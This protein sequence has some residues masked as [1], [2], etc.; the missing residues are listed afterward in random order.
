[1]KLA[2]RGEVGPLG[3]KANCFLH[4]SSKECVH[5]YIEVNYQHW[6]QSSPLEMND[7]HWHQ[8]SPLEVNYHHWHQFS[9]LEMNE[10]HWDQSSS[11]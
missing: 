9:P 3:V 1:M 2:S 7:H 5:P 6:D 11:L 8:S 4:H 10:H